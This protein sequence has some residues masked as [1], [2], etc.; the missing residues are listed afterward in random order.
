M[1]I[2]SIEQYND[3]KKEAISKYLKTVE[4]VLWQ[5]N[6]TM[7]VLKRTKE[8]IFKKLDQRQEKCKRKGVVMIHLTTHGEC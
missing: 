8:D 5:D 7:S 4:D 1:T 6:D 2:L 3:I